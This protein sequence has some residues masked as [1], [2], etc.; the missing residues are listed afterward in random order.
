MANSVTDKAMLDLQAAGFSVGS[1]TDREMAYLTSK[2][3]GVGSFA[4]KSKGLGRKLTPVSPA[5]S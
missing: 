1:I 2:S 3:P 4:G 5:Y